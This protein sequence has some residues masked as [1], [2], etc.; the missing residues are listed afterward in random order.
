MKPTIDEIVSHFNMQ[1]HPE[2]GYFC[3]TYRSLLKFETPSGERASST[4][5]LF[6]ITKDSISHFHRLTSDE[7]WHFYGGSP[8]KLLQINACKTKQLLLH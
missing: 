8:L 4:A 2:G 7:G 5:I 6:L 1:P 3:E